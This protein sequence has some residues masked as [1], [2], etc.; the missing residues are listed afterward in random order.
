MHLYVLHTQR[1]IKHA[2]IAYIYVCLYAHILAY[3]HMCVYGWIF[4]LTLI[5]TFLYIIFSIHVRWNKEVP[6][7]CLIDTFI[8]TDFSELFLDTVYC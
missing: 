2:Y 7:F 6:K 5:C 3:M 4:P 8:R 1:H